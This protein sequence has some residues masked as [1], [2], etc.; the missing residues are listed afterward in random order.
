MLWHSMH[1]TTSSKQISTQQIQLK[2]TTKTKNIYVQT[3]INIC[4]T[5]QKLPYLFVWTQNKNSP[6]PPWVLPPKLCSWIQPS[7]APPPLTNQGPPGSSWDSPGFALV[8]FFLSD[9]LWISSLTASASHS[10]AGWDFEI[11]VQSLLGPGLG[12]SFLT[13]DT[14]G[15]PHSWNPIA[16]QAS[17][18]A[19]SQPSLR[20]LGFRFN[21]EAS[22]HPPKK[23]VLKLVLIS[24]SN[25]HIQWSEILKCQ[26][27]LGR[28]KED[29]IKK[30]RETPHKYRDTVVLYPSEQN[31]TPHIKQYIPRFPKEGSFATFGETMKTNDNL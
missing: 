9:F 25:K 4:F 29:L 27:L 1:F 15:P 2:E 5:Y 16:V 17:R 21:R 19:R 26:K 8:S 30:L 24:I 22:T 31:D 23:S 6:K 18:T 3:N 28:S 12:F 20:E 14:G 13:E 7:V 10:D 11:E